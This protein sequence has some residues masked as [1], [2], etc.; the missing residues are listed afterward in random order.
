MKSLVTPQW[1]LIVHEKLGQQLYDW[2]HDPGELHN[3]SGTPE[4]QEIARHLASQMQDLLTRS[5]SSSSGPGQDLESSTRSHD[6]NHPL[7]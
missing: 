2:I 3:V 5:A 6:N 7:H 4:G 1:H